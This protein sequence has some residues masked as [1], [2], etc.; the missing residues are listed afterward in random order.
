MYSISSEYAADAVTGMY[1]GPRTLEALQTFLSTIMA[2]PFLQIT[3]MSQLS[4]FNRSS[5]L[6]SGNNVVFVFSLHSSLSARSLSQTSLKEVDYAQHL[7]LK[8]FKSVAS[9]HYM[10]AKFAILDEKTPPASDA[11]PWFHISKVEVPQ[12]SE[13]S[14][15]D[16]PFIQSPYL[17]IDRACLE[18]EIDSFVRYQNQPLLNELDNHNFKLFSHLGRLV[19]IAVI[20]PKNP[21]KADQTS[22]ILES[23]EAAAKRVT[24]RDLS[25]PLEVDG[26]GATVPVFAFLDAVK[27]RKFIKRYRVKLP[28]LLVID[29][30]TEK[31]AGFSL[32]EIMSDDGVRERVHAVVEDVAARRVEMVDIAAPTL[33]EKIA[34][35]FRDYYPWSLF[36]LLGPLILLSLSFFVTPYPDDKKLK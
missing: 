3:D 21:K 25:R 7:S 19:L 27:W 26:F 15:D 29:F 23:L 9:K 18:V 30:D 11:G 17:C 34:Y 1:N 10:H 20:D 36:I 4:G 32:R 33:V 24:Y 22:I 6:H 8:A 13:L 28:S 16:A 2:P 35:R 12:K 5:Y 14:F 31:Y